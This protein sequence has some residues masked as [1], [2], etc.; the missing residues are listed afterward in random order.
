MRGDTWPNRVR[1]AIFV[2]PAQT[3]AHRR[4]VLAMQVA[5]QRP[6]AAFNQSL[7]TKHSYRCRWRRGSHLAR[8]APPCC[9]YGERG[10]TGETWARCRSHQAMCCSWDAHRS[11]RYALPQAS[12]ASLLHRWSDPSTGRTL[13]ACSCALRRVPDHHA[14]CAYAR[15]SLEGCTAAQ[16]LISMQSAIYKYRVC[17]HEPCALHCARTSSATTV[18]PPQPPLPP[19]CTH[20]FR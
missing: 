16:R 8:S 9:C 3:C 10:G 12:S 13:S 4:T 2:F 7:V 15:A 18:N 17:L 6:C 20:L 1:S 14:A 5:L 19:C 11:Y